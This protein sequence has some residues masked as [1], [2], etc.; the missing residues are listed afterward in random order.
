MI[1]YYKL[2]DILNKRD[3]TK[4]QLRI[5][6]GLASGTMTKI[7]KGEPVNLKTIDLI[8]E[9]LQVQPGDILEYIK[10]KSHENRENI[11]KSV[12]NHFWVW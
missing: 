12:D 8:C 11:Q 9:A 3:M 5:K 6:A 10:N 4:E 1:A 2:L 7:S